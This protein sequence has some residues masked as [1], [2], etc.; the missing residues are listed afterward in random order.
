M[1]IFDEPTTGLHFHD[2]KKLLNAFRL[3]VDKGHTLVVI[4][5]HPDVIKC[6]DWLVDLGP[7]GGVNGGNLVFQGIPEDILKNKK[8][9]TAECLKD[10]L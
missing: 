2:I 7:E 6:A 10:K 4:E 8:S 3:L 9:F 1:F 5:H